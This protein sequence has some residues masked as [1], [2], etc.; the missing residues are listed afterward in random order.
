MDKCVKPPKKIFEQRQEGTEEVIVV[1]IWWKITPGREWRVQR[2]DKFDFQE[3]SVTGKKS[4]KGKSGGV[5][6]EVTKD[7]IVE[8][9]RSVQDP[10]SYWKQ[11]KL[12]ESFT[13][14][15]AMKCF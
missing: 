1:D 13:Q 2:P 14:S 3:A 15:S 9:W 11:W 12:L 10:A 4:A 5:S 8:C 6:S 7:W